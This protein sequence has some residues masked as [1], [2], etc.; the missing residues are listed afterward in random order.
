MHSEGRLDLVVP[1]LH[2]AP[3]DG[4]DGDEADGLTEMPL[5]CGAH[6]FEWYRTSARFPTI[7][8]VV[9]QYS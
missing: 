3:A 8:T 5:K 9:P 6:W 2:G 7:M 4:F 1:A